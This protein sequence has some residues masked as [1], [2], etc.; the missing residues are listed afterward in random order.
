MLFA[1]RLS[2]RTLRTG[3]P[4]QLRLPG[5]ALASMQQHASGRALPAA[6]AS[7]AQLWAVQTTPSGSRSLTTFLK[8][9]LR[10]RPNIFKNHATLVKLAPRGQQ[11]RTA[12]W[13]NYT[14]ANYGSDRGNRYRN[15]NYR[16]P[17][18]EQFT[19]E[20]TVYTLIAL[21][22]A[23]FLV[24][25]SALGRE[26]S[27]GDSKL[28]RWM[29]RNFTT[30]WVNL[31][32][33]RLWTLITP[34]F[35]HVE[36]MHLLVNMFVLYN[37]GPDLARMLG[38]R[39]FLAFYLGAAVCG[40][41][42]S[43]VLR[44]MMQPRVGAAD[45]RT[46]PSLGAS[47][48]VVGITTLFACLFPQTRFLIFFVVPVPAW[49]ATAGFIAWDLMG[50]AKHR[51]SRTDGAGHLGGAAAALGYYWFRK[52]ENS[53]PTSSLQRSLGRVSTG[54]KTSLPE[55]CWGLDG[56]GFGTLHTQ[57]QASCQTRRPVG[58]SA[59]TDHSWGVWRKSCPAPDGC[60]AAAER[61][62][63]VGGSRRRPL[64]QS[65]VVAAGT[66][67]GQDQ[68]GSRPAD[69]GDKGG[70]PADA[71]GAGGAP[72]Q[73]PAGGRG[74]GA[75]KTAGSDEDDDDDDDGDD[76]DGSE[77][78]EEDDGDVRCVCGER[79]DGELM[80][81]CEV[82]QVW[83]HTLCMGIRDEA[84]IPDQ[85]YCE[86]CRPE[87]HPYINSRPRTA[88]LADA[89][90][91]GTSTMMRRSAVMAVAKMT[92]REEYRTAAA[93]AAIA[94]SVAAAA[95]GQG[96]GGGK[97]TPKKAGRSSGA[98]A[99]KS[100]RRSRRST[101]G[102]ADDEAAGASEE[103]YGGSQS[104]SSGATGAARKPQTPRRPAATPAGGPSKRRRTTAAKPP[105]GLNPPDDP[106]PRDTDDQQRTKGK[107]LRTTKSRVRSISTLAHKTRSPSR[108]QTSG[109]LRE[110]YDGVPEDAR[111][112]H[113]E[114]G[115]PQ[116]LSPSPG[117]QAFL[118]GDENGAGK[119]AAGGGGK[120]RRA[121]TTAR[122]RQRKAVSASNSPF[123][124]AEGGAGFA[125]FGD[126]AAFGR[127]A[128]AGSDD[129]G[130]SADDRSDAPS[131]QPQ[132]QPQQQ[133]RAPRQVFPPQ[134]MVDVDGNRI[135]V[136]SHMLNAHGQPM[137]SSIT[138]DTMCKIRYPHSR[139]SLY[140]LNRRA[141]QMLEWL[142]KTQSEY[143]HERL[144]LVWRLIRFQEAYSGF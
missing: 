98:A 103:D 55:S 107:P 117:L 73:Q 59:G 110:I 83:Q 133:Q 125:A 101:R 49:L 144:S 36:P 15:H 123:I 99:A 5:G 40:N 35:S 131:L 71:E 24:W 61:R 66:S 10:T 44:G 70:A 62:A 41:L 46:A 48:S 124:A 3:L 84:H 65:A 78:D 137:Y 126:E 9:T 42:I 20:A 139:A 32:E 136:P 95:T 7:M 16:K 28:T 89:A 100:G 54:G 130:H 34:A 47:T 112:G 45:P 26:R 135:V 104:P 43:A 105:G 6:A 91:L 127:G 79:N 67:H 116:R 82:C 138:A 114:P 109:E 60:T 17:F 2:T 30:M 29:M 39:R 121:G 58:W 96:G 12:R 76:E 52:G 22:G 90:M 111:R 97:R 69:S 21:N 81:Q 115:S 8:S 143:E 19:P 142:G 33:G 25:Q 38:N 119:D 77:D 1:A 23:V 140:D 72:D 94:A 51:N 93:V 134:E 75:D 13:E 64:A 129:T 53:L 106:E 50:V 102:A 74:R 56:L 86:A 4:S 132:Q 113:S 37:F 80:I 31:S 63:F 141:K 57:T 88:V 11:T 128:A 122:G 92:A 108:R 27:F 118:F 68:H 14:K 18:F 85:Y 87:D 120:R